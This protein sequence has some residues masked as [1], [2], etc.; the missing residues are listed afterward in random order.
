MKRKPELYLTLIDEIAN[1]FVNAI[2]NHYDI[3]TTPRPSKNRDPQNYAVYMIA[4]AVAKKT[5]LSHE[6]VFEQ[7]KTKQYHGFH[8]P[9]SEEPIKIKKKITGKSILLIDDVYNSGETLKI[10]R[11]A[12]VD[13]KNAVDCM[14][15]LNYDS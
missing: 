3:V 8:H 12:L 14:V 4:D 2:N 7:S 15:Y 5:G 13:M 1:H 6:I 9:A 10:H 11:Q